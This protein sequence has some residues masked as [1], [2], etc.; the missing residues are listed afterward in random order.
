[1]VIGAT[2]GLDTYSTLDERGCGYSNS[3]PCISITGRSNLHGGVVVSVLSL[4]RG[5]A[6]AKMRR[7]AL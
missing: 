3:L 5:A 2:T 7:Y 1:M 4:G 6:L